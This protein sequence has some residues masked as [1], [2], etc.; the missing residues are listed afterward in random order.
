ML[1]LFFKERQDIVDRKEGGVVEDV[2][3]VVKGSGYKDEGNE[4]L[5]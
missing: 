3:V 1:M 4:K 5:I 2:V